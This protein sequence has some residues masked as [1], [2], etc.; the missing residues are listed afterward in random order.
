MRRRS[1]TP[2]L[3]AAVTSVI[4]GLLRAGVAADGGHRVEGEDDPEGT[5]LGVVASRVVEL[6]EQRLEATAKLGGT[7]GG[8]SGE[9]ARQEER[10]LLRRS[11][12]RL[13]RAEAERELH[14]RTGGVE[15]GQQRLVED[16]EARRLIGRE[17]RPV[18]LERERRDAVP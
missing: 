9:A 3:G 5:C 8:K 6:L 14:L 7:F 13:D 12:I 15:H 16:L 2:M 10:V 17:Q 18:E 11:G 1:R 4:G